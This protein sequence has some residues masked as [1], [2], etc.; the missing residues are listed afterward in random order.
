M[1]LADTQQIDWLLFEIAGPFRRG[2]YERRTTVAHQRA[3]EQMQWIGDHA[4]SQHV[5]NRNRL[6]H[7]GCWIKRRMLAACDCD[8][9]PLLSR[10]PIGVLVGAREQSVKGRDGSAVWALE[11]R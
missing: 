7:L 2:H 4:R 8:C 6:A 9:R 5:L 10:G 1:P 3:V 11:L